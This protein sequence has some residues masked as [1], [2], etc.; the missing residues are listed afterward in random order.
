MAL[1]W[2]QKYTYV[3]IVI[4]SREFQFESYLQ[5]RNCKIVEM[6]DN[7]LV[8]GSDFDSL[9]QLQAVIYLIAC[10]S[11]TFIYTSVTW[12]KPRLRQ[13]FRYLFL[14]MHGVKSGFSIRY[15]YR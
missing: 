13:G 15:I 12:D 8:T 14:Y 2:L 9:Y 1:E 3:T 5:L 10:L 6:Y 4:Q 11:G 7:I